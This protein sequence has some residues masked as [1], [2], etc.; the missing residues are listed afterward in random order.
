MHRVQARRGPTRLSG[1]F[2][3][4]R[5]IFHFRKGGL[6]AG[7]R[8]EVQRR[9]RGVVSLRS[10]PS[11]F[12]SSFFSST[13]SRARYRRSSPT[14]RSLCDDP[15]PRKRSAVS[16]P[17][18]PVVTSRSSHLHSTFVSLIARC[19]RF[20]S[21][22]AKAGNTCGCSLLLLLFLLLVIVI[23]VVVLV[24]GESAS[25]A[26]A[27]AT[28]FI[29]HEPVAR[30]EGNIGIRRASR[31]GRNARRGRSSSSLFVADV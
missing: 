28:G 22:G 26:I 20:F 17:A 24:S 12:S 10:V 15:I 21:A 6:S 18:A 14:R 23:V 2:E 25:C 3:T 4:G 30:R 19:R 8:E 29:I 31:A 9:R 13:R 11:P 27:L 5:R 1:R 16:Q 7:E